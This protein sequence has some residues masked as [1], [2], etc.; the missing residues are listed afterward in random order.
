MRN[1]HTFGNHLFLRTDRAYSADEWP[2]KP[3][4]PPAAAPLT[5][6]GSAV[7]DLSSVV[8]D[9]PFS[10]HR[11]IAYRFR[12]LSIIAATLPADRRQELVDRAVAAA[13]AAAVASGVPP[14]PPPAASGAS[15]P[16]ASAAASAASRELLSDSLYPRV[17]VEAAVARMPITMDRVAD[18][19]SNSSGTPPGGSPHASSSSS[20]DRQ[21]S[22][23]PWGGKTSAE[24]QVA[25]LLEVGLLLRSGSSPAAFSQI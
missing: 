24:E 16:P 2:S 21:R 19:V 9:G 11:M 13:T 25:L 17:S 14:G 4:A 10:Y 22:G 20:E 8:K 7:P 15:A 23:I 1:F 5:G 12:V 3:T 6:N 18:D